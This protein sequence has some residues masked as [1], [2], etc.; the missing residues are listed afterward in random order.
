MRPSKLDLKASRKR[1]IRARLT[2]TPERPRLTVTV[3]L[4][5]ISVQVIDDTA[6]KTLASA[7]SKGKNIAAATKLGEAIA[8]K[9]KDA[10][11][12]TIVFDRNGLKYHG[13]IKALADAAR[14]AGLVF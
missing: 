9:C 1:R 7:A 4:T 3:S 10:K 13:R 5:R 12:T 8:K 14:A 2:G 11:I 6:S